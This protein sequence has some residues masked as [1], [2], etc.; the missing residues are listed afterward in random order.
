MTNIHSAST[1]TSEDNVNSI[2]SLYSETSHYIER[3]PIQ[4]NSWLG[5]M[6]LLVTASISSEIDIKHS[7]SFS[8]SSV[9][10]CSVYDFDKREN[11]DILHDFVS[12]LI[13]NSE[14]LDGRIVDMVNEKFWDLI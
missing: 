1:Y 3:Q 13:N 6:F 14:D 4:K 9:Y 10:Q 11:M 5:L 7:D 12:S 8:L 2:S